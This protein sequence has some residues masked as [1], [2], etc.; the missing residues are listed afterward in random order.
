MRCRH[1]GVNWIRGS[2][3]VVFIQHTN[4]NVMQCSLRFLLF[5]RENYTL[6]F[7]RFSCKILTLDLL[8]FC[9]QS[10]VGV[11][12][13]I[14]IACFILL[15]FIIS[16]SILTKMRF[17]LNSYTRETF[18]GFLTADLQPFAL[19]YTL[20]WTLFYGLVYLF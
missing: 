12:S 20:F 18:I 5:N 11:D 14:I 10:S 16:I 13:M 4:Y 9:V 6:T 15:H 2:W 7:L 8:F 19:S 1:F 3:C 17:D